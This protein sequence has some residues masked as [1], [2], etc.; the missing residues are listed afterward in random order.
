MCE[1]ASAPSKCVCKPSELQICSS[2]CC[3]AMTDMLTSPRQEQHSQRLPAPQSLPALVQCEHHQQTAKE[4]RVVIVHSNP[5]CKTHHLISVDLFLCFFTLSLT[6]SCGKL[7]IPLLLS[8]IF[9]L[10]AGSRAR[11]TWD[12]GR[13]CL[14]EMSC[15]DTRFIVS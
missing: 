1:I 15:Q 8:V 11:S 7:R 9:V 5:H 4:D 13:G 14:E 12:S 10:L 3:A 2:K 6:C